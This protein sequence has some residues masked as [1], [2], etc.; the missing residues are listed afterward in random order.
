MSKI[1]GQFLISGQ[2]QDSCEISGISGQLGALA[3]FSNISK[4]NP[5]TIPLLLYPQKVYHSRSWVKEDCFCSCQQLFYCS[6]HFLVSTSVLITILWNQKY[7]M[8]T[9]KHQS[10][11][12]LLLLTL[13]SCSVRGS[14]PPSSSGRISGS[15]C[16]CSD[17]RDDAWKCSYMHTHTHTEKC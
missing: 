8:L 1:S 16:L 7:H 11:G 17:S 14:V 9:Y 15:K 2:L 13:A 5:S 4:V 6:M 3:L 12:Q 10:K